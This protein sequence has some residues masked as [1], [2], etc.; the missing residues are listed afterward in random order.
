M[1]STLL[2]TGTNLGVRGFSLAARFLIILI[3][4]RA[5]GPSEFGVFTIIQT[6]E[7]IAILV[8]GF[9]FNAYSRREIVNAVDPLLR[10]E[11]IRNQIFI[12]ILLGLISPAIAFGS[13][14]A[15]LFPIN[16]RHDFPGRHSN[17]VRLT[18]NLDGEHRLFRA[19]ERVGLSDHDPFCLQPARDHDLADA[20]DLVRLL[21]GRHLGVLLEP[22]EIGLVRNFPSSDK[23]AMDI[24]R[25]CGC[26]AIFR[27]HSLR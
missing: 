17:S 19:V 6:T 24:A 1:F 26:A 4:A 3:L 25:V 2:L 27:K 10:G 13:A 14:F 16:L 8:L 9:E 5:L 23:L 12:A 11:H 18:A 15:G 21:S 20:G 22:S 7:I